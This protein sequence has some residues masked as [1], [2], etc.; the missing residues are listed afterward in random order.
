VV[1]SNQS[2]SVLLVVASRLIFAV[3]RDGVLPLSGWLSRV[4]ADGQ[5]HNAIAFIFIF[6]ALLLCTILPSTVA[7]TSLVSAGGLPTFAAYSLIG[8][9]RLTQTPNN[10]LSSKFKLW[11]FRLPYY[12][13]TALFNLIAIAVLVS[14]FYFPVTAE[15][16][17]FVSKS[18]VDHVDFLSFLTARCGLREEW[19][20]VQ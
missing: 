9:L 18:V 10:F 7:F 17:N 5:P 3:A 19:F 20:S 13:A 15:T 14:P 1:P 4:T 2:T 8:L 12:A 6:D 16:F 11:P